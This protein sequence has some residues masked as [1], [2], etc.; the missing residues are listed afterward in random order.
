[1]KRLRIRFEER[2]AYWPW[3]QGHQFSV[4]WH[5]KMWIRCSTLRAAKFAVRWLKRRKPVRGIMFVEIHVGD[6]LYLRFRND[7]RFMF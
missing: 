3:T 2:P 6:M 7:R 1:M 4:W 5:G